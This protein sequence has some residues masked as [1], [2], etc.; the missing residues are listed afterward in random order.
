MGVTVERAKRTQA[1]S[2]GCLLT[3]PHGILHKPGDANALPTTPR[4]RRRREK[5][6][7]ESVKALK[8]VRADSEP[9]K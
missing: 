1:D 8:K 9:L 3:G 2:L 5:R 6:E 4:C 7:K